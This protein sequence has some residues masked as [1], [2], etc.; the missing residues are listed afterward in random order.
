MRIYTKSVTNLNELFLRRMWLITGV[1]DKKLMKATKLR[2]KREKLWYKKSTK[3]E[4]KS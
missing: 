1:T 3:K 4:E 2:H